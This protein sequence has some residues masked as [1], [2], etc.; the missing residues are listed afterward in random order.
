MFE[1]SFR[2]RAHAFQT[3]RPV[4]FSFL[5]SSGENLVATP[6]PLDTQ[7]SRLL[8]HVVLEAKE[9][10]LG[11]DVLHDAHDGGVLILGSRCSLA[12]GLAGMWPS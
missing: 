2:A 5:H 6:A 3:P 8:P 4:I 9:D 10:G 11:T 12:V 7:R 1:L